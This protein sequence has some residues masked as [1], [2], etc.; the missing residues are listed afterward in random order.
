MSAAIQYNSFEDF[1]R[2]ASFANEDRELL[3]D[4]LAT[5]ARLVDGIH[6]KPA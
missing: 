2:R 5:A 6:Q 3:R 4:W 1:D